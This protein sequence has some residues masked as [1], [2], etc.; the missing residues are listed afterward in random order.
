MI[1]KILVAYDGSKNSD[2]AFDFA[3][4][5]AS[6]YKAKVTVLSVARPSEPPEDVET[7][8]ALENAIEHFEKLYPILKNKAKKYSI[9]PQFLI[10]VGHPADQIVNLANEEKTSMIIMGHRGKSVVAR[11]LLGSI[12]KRVLSYARCTVSIVR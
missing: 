6:K 1:K 2:K 10:R 7:E 11:W 12:S 9:V 5:I 8:A 4:D 3:L